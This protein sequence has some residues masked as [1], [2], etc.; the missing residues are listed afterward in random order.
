MNISTNFIRGYT[1][2][3]GFLLYIMGF[4]AIVLI[5]RKYDPHDLIFQILL[6]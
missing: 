1:V 5:V 3:S 4:T 6:K 2:F